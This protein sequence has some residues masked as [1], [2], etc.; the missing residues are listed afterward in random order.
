MA[1]DK[2][3]KQAH[4]RLKMKPYEPRTVGRAAFTLIEMLVVILIIAILAALLLPTLG[5]AKA[6]ARQMTCLN[7]MKQLGIGMMMYVGDNNSV[8]AGCASANDYGAQLPD[9]I[10]WRNPTVIDGVTYTLAQSP[11]V[12]ELGTGGSTNIFRCPMDLDN[13]QRTGTEPFNFSYAFTSFNMDGN[14]NLGITTIIDG[15]TPYL[16]KQTQVNAPANKIMIAEGV[17]SLLTNEC[18]APGFVSVAA[19]HSPCL[20]S[21]RWQPFAAVTPE[22]P[23]GIDN[24]LTIRHNGNADVTFA[25]GHVQGVPWEFGT[26]TNNTLPSY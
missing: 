17:T 18:P 11:L 3:V 9:W 7:N 21:G 12:A 24:F 5:K 22:T 25:D 14:E 23:D 16:F 6:K 15:D 10:Y 1:R 4:I 19:G 20:T 13:T 2:K 26:T 8:F